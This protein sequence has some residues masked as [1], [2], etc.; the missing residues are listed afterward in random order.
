LSEPDTETL[1]I[2]RIVG[3]YGIKGWVKI[4]SFTEPAE[5]L[6]GY[7]GWKIRRRDRW[8]EIEFDDGQQHG[9]GLVAHI[10]GVDHR[11]AAELLKGC[12]IAVPRSQLPALESNEYYWYQLE[13]LTVYAGNTLLGRVDHLMETG[14]N[15]VLVVRACEGSLDSR[16]RLIPWLLGQTV[17]SVDLDAGRIEVD[18]DPAF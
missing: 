7:R 4:H 2:G 16:E 17:R 3:A 5:N 9:K 15:D 12:D 6:L 13:G 18:W 8:E 1:V 10:R 11:D 14:A